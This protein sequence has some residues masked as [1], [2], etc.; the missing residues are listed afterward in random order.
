MGD[1]VAL[2][3]VPLEVTTVQKP[4]EDKPAA[5]KPAF[6][7]TDEALRTT[8][9]SKRE[10]IEFIQAQ[11]CTRFLAERKLKGTVKNLMKVTKKEQLIEIYEE[12]YDLNAFKGSDYDVEPE[13]EQIVEETKSLSVGD[14]KPA[15]IVEVTP[16]FTKSVS[17]KGDKTN[18]PKPGDW[19]SCYYIGK[20]E[21]D[22]VF[23]QLQPGTKKKRNQPIKFRVGKG[24]VIKGW[25]EGVMTMSVGEKAE[26]K[27]E[28]EWAYGKK[29]KPEAGIPPNST[30]IF[31]VEL[32]RID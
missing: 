4:S 29:G 22:K 9:I 10:L 19:V 24:N 17:K 21:N 25:D 18:F 12:M 30:L 26:L 20:L 1:E 6:Q 28:P 23:D 32:V 27:I 15:E 31:E 7:W 8:E 11:A 14:A 3:K 13:L 5:E 2:D 16:R